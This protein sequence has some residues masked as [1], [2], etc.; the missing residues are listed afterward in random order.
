MIVRATIGLGNQLFQY[1][2]A[3]ALQKKGRKV[4]IDI[5]IC[6]G[7]E[8]QNGSQGGYQLDKYDIDIKSSQEK[9]NNKFYRNNLLLN[10]LS[11]ALPQL[12]IKIREKDFTFDSKLLNISGNKYVEG[13]FQSQQY[14]QNIRDTLLQQLVI[15]QDLSEYTQSIEKKIS[16]SENSC[17]IHVRRGDYIDDDRAQ[18]FGSCGMSYYA[19]AVRIINDKYKG[20][21]FFIFSDDINWVVENLKIDN[22]VYVNSKEKRIP[23]EDIH[24]MSLCDNN[25]IA[26]SSFSWWGAWLNKNDTK[27]V[28][29]PKI[30]F[31]KDKSEARSQTIVCNEW[32]RI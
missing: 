2:Y 30:W 23:H 15:K 9:G 18:V 5:F 1:A 20:T 32:I 14:F 4:E 3:K 21:K 10:L 7:E 22:A 29:A 28:I 31:A 19:Q 11:K 12:K 26:N 17:S 24:L 25:I 8:Y 6:E 13:Y 16:N 27:T